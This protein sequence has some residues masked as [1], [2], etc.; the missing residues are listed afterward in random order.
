MLGELKGF[1]FE[2]GSSFQFRIENLVDSPIYIYLIVVDSAGRIEST[3]IWRD[4]YIDW[5]GLAPGETAL[6]YIFRVTKDGEF[7]G[8]NEFRFFSSPQRINQL[9]RPPASGARG[10]LQGLQNLQDINLSDLK[11]IRTKVVYYSGI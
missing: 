9:S 4:D 8:I 3:P 7:S 1:Y 6:S 2:D 10:G 5:Q 11:K